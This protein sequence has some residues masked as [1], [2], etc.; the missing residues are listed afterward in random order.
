MKDLQVNTEIVNINTLKPNPKN[1][2][3]A[4]REAMDRLKRQIE[5]LG[6][7]KP[8]IIDTRTGFII[9]GH[10]RYDALKEMGASNVLVSYITS[11]NDTEALEYMLSDNDNVGVT[12]KDQLLELIDNCEN[13]NLNDYATNFEEPETLD[14]FMA[15]FKNENIEE[16]EPPEVSEGE[17]ISKLGEVYQLGRHRLMCGDSTKIE[18]VEKLTEGKKADMV[19]TDPPY[20]IAYQGGS[21]KRE[22]IEN[23]KVDNFYQFLLDAYT[24]MFT[25]TK[26][27]S[28]FY[29]CH[30]DSERVNFTK[31]F[32]DAGGYL[33]S[34][35]IW[36]KN[37]STFGRSD[38]F[39]KHE[40]ILYGWNQLGSHQWYG[41]RKQDTVWNIDRPSKSE[42]HPTMKPIALIVKAMKN[43]SKDEDIV[44]DL[45]GG[46]GSTLIASEQTNRICYMMEIDPRY[47][48]VVRK[49]YAK[50]IGKEEEWE[51]ITKCV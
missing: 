2:R 18:D 25:F 20:N 17:A 50:F 8:I 37:N 34:V 38:Y 29:V 6:Q 21:K 14:D 44:L 51:S 7:Y 42:E 11:E 28:A 3:T 35:I 46:S 47:C 15:Q 22:M 49:R 13:L 33:S 48:D 39:W 43:S 30:A 41:D 27:G 26:G 31:A 4:T 1:P 23:D 12:E 9:G 19:F 16:D 40:P 45:F 24:S 36:A 10:R 32:K 5:K